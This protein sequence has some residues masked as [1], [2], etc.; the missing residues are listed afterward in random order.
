[1]IFV[2]LLPLFVLSSWRRQKL[3][4]HTFVSLLLRAS[5]HKYDVG[6][7]VSRDDIYRRPPGTLSDL[8]SEHVYFQGGLLCTKRSIYKKCA[9]SMT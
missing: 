2:L 9:K 3:P 7:S 4:L 8:R 6:K 1:M 5:M